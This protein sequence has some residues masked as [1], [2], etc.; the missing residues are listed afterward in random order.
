MPSTLFRHL[1]LALAGCLLSGCAAAQAAWPERPIQLIV[2]FPAGG[3]VDV[4]ARPF[5]ERFGELLHQP[6]VVVPRDG[7]AGTIGMGVVAAAKP[8]GYMLAFSP[9][10]PITIQPHVIPSLAYKADSLQPVCQLFASEYVLAVRA[11][12]PYKSLDDLVK[13]ARAQPG[14]LTY[15][16]GGVATSPH[17]AIA[18]FANAA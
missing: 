18:E 15:G 2:P 10:G 9:S 4:I 1:S 3:G 12:S 7:A 8:D 16:F 17:L 14:K 6:V 11:D 5:A 13:A